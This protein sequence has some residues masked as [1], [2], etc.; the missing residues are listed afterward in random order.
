M[1]DPILLDSATWLT[2]AA[3]ARVALCGSHG[4]VYCGWCAAKHGVAALILHDAGIG[5]AQAGIGS[6]PWL[7]ELGVPAAAVA[8]DT[9]RIGEAADMVSRGALS[10]CNDAA[11][12]LGLAPGMSAR[13]ALDRLLA[14]ALPPS[15]TPPAFGEARHVL[16]P[17]IVAVD[18][19]ALV[20]AED[21][22]GIVV[23]GSHAG[24]PGNDPAN[25]VGFDVAAA[26]YNDAGIGIERAGLAR[27]A[28]LDRRGIAAAAVSC[29]SA[30]I[31]N[32]L[33]TWNDGVVSALN[34]AAHAKGGR[35]GQT[36]QELVA[37]MLERG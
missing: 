35:V 4:G 16:V 17:G 27:L 11:S 21:V 19:N 22:G 13:E 28:A 10:S 18:S 8:H 5:R 1:P 30:R 14:A 6:L 33:S 3:H 31:G 29:F 7:D 24:L 25:A 9:A 32:S 37:A 2:D 34:G 20:T 12:R 23:T 15:P 26:I 36:T